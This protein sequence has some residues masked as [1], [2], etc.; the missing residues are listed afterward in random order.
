MGRMLFAIAF[1]QMVVYL[2][3]LQISIEYVWS[4]FSVLD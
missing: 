1:E 2:R 4:T 3:K